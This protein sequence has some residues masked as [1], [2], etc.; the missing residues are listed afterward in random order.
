MEKVQLKLAVNKLVSL[1]ATLLFLG[2]SCSA[3]PCTVDTAKYG[4]VCKE[5]PSC[6]IIGGT[7]ILEWKSPNPTKV[8]VVCIHGLGLCARAYSPLAEKF[9][10]AGIDGFAINVRGF[11][12]DRDKAERAKLNCL[13]TVGDVQTLLRS[14][15][16]E[17]PESKIFLIGE[18]MGGALAI[19][20]AAESPEL[21][22]G[23]VCSAPAWK[24]LKVKQTAIKGVV[25]LFLLKNSYPGPAGRS[26][27]KQA[28]S[29]SA[30]VKHWTSDDSHKLKLTPR[31]ASAFL[32]FVSKTDRYATQQKKPVLIVQG[33]QD[34]LVSP[35]AVARLYSEIPV[36]NKTFLIDAEGEHLVLEEGLFSQS[37]L[38]HLIKWMQTQMTNSVV[39]P[40]VI[41]IN[42]S[43][44]TAAQT[45]RLETLK[46]LAGDNKTNR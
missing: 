21:I 36:K 19:R 38:E 14:I 37:L 35:Q 1:S 8:T 24:L 20:I 11:G 26:V 22:D 13:D 31:E 7:H 23:I 46:N 45:K 18:S 17:K 29:D 10:A 16:K 6:V 4:R 33:L 3:E 25:E 43:S 2:S 15:R 42:D 28:T 41:S 30:L 27:V 34:H 9:T 44:L 5:D 12:P 40:S 32:S 39:I